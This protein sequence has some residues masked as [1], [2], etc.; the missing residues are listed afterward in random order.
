M[1]AAELKRLKEIQESL[2][3]SASDYRDRTGAWPPTAPGVD[4][5]HPAVESLIPDGFDPYHGLGRDA[6]MDS[7]TNPDGSLM[8]ADKT[9]H[10]EG[11]LSATDRH[12]V[13][14]PVGEVID[15]FGPP[16][17]R[18]TSPPGVSYPERALPPTNLD[19]GYHQYEVI[20]PLPVWRGPIAP[21]MGE[22]GLGTQHYLP[23]SVQA[24]IAGG[25]LREVPPTPLDMSAPGSSND[26][27]TA[28]DSGSGSESGSQAQ[29]HPFDDGHPGFSLMDE[30]D[31]FYRYARELE[32]LPGHY[33]VIAHGTPNSISMDTT[34]G[35]P[36]TPR[37]LANLIRHRADYEPGT[38]VRLLSC[39]TGH[40][41]GNFAS[42]LA[43]CLNAPVV[44]PDGYLYINASG[45]LGV[46]RA[47][48]RTLH[49]SRVPDLPNTFHRFHPDGRVEELERSD[50]AGTQPEAGN[51]ATH[52][53]SS[54]TEI[55]PVGADPSEALRPT[56]PTAVA[57]ATEQHS[58]GTSPEPTDQPA[59][60]NS[61]RPFSNVDHLGSPLPADRTPAPDAQYS[62]PTG[63]EWDAV[64]TAAIEMADRMP[65]PPKEG[66]PRMAAALQMPDGTMFSGAS[67]RSID[68]TEFPELE[69]VIQSIPAENQSQFAW[70]CAELDCIT[71][72]L[73]AGYKLSDLAGAMSSAAQI[74][75]RNS[76]NHGKW[77][78]PC[79]GDSYLLGLLEIRW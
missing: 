14:L 9:T 42:R 60:S 12:P 72:A 46:D 7:I 41:D 79:L 55:R 20:R 8:W 25:Y 65:R 78:Q 35:R 39:N 5:D 76:S 30:N 33:D 18:F 45:E 26:F 47:L 13:V 10:P 73:R 54:P 22:A 37:E 75:G 31:R 1:D 57:A 53:S 6:W 51:T 2:N 27:S 58:P 69:A 4:R 44:A 36:M 40:L 24:L 32:P 66:D 59:S 43:R 70:Q 67:N 61:P 74:R 49:P 15:R 48:R 56:P 16:V 17:G 3:K 68:I 77:R 23:V 50:V 63:S 38:P 52:A 34:D 19:N 28:E 11:F 21:Q 71:Q 62:E 64:R 29:T